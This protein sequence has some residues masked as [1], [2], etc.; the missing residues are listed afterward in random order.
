MI[1]RERFLTA[2]RREVPDRVPMGMVHFN[3]EAGRLFKERTGTDNFAEYFGVEYD[4]ESVGFKGSNID[5]KMY[6]RF[7]KDLP[8]S[9][10]FNEWGTA[11]VVGSDPAFDRHIAPL[12]DI[13]S[14]KELEDYPLSDLA[15][16][17][18][19][20]HLEE[21]V[22]RIHQKG[23]AVVAQMQV[24]IFEVAWQ[25]RG[26]N[27]L[28]TDFLLR[29]EYA[30]CLVDRLT[31]LRCFQARRYAE[32][33]ADIIFTGDDVGMED[34]LMMSPEVWWKWLG[35]RMKKIISSAREVNPEVL[36]CYHSDGYL[37]PL[38]PDFINIG[39]DCLNPVQPECMDP[40]KLKQEH[41]DRLA[42]WGTISIQQTMPFGTPEDV[43]KE[44]KERIDT[45]GPGGGFVIS[46]THVLAPE[47]PLENMSAFVE[48]VKEY[49][50]YES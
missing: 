30:Q 28:L 35:S 13:K 11:F 50:V 3:R 43:R 44:V 33:G 36:F 12:T 4:Y 40:A 5:P 39:I 16:D 41:G 31:E 20:K 10:R 1:P 7:H 23:L 9:A 21:E 6:A 24:T 17:Y 48:A 2:L 14:I 29:E 27:E 18:R 22:N 45:V 15:A 37:V 25:N 42:F 49:G 26:F 38:I 46:P 19:H 34:R 32:A 47:V 8:E